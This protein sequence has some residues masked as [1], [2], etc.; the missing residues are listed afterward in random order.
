MIFGAPHPPRFIDHRLCDT[1]SVGEH[2]W[3]AT[4]RL[5]NNAPPLAAL[6]GAAGCSEW[7]WRFVGCLNE[8]DWTLPFFCR[9][10]RCCVTCCQDHRP[11]SGAILL[12]R[13]LVLEPGKCR[14]C[15]CEVLWYFVVGKP[16]PPCVSSGSLHEALYRDPVTFLDD[17]SLFTQCLR[18][19]K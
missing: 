1:V 7:C 18:N 4:W 17:S 16:A 12:R 6:C 10:A 14:S 11:H 3:F 19:W 2:S 13:V 5:D 15:L 9:V 8:R